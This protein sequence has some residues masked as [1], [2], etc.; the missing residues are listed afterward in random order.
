[1]FKRSRSLPAFVVL[2]LIIGLILVGAG[3]YFINLV[4]NEGADDMIMGAVG[5]LI[6]GVILVIMAIYFAVMSWG[7]PA[8]RSSNKDFAIS[9]EVDHRLVSSYQAT[10]SPKEEYVNSLKDG[11]DVSF[12]FDPDF[13]GMR[14]IT[15]RKIGGAYYTFVSYSNETSGYDFF[16]MPRQN[17]A[18]RLNEV[19]ACIENRKPISNSQLIKIKKYK[20]ILSVYKV[21]DPHYD[22]MI[23]K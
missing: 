17:A 14:K 18:E 12:I 5:A 1:M 9:V 4:I 6:V 21:N 8:G 10:V 7:S 13:L 15:L 19:C 2:G 20:S 3:I 23:R 11:K 22:E 16:L